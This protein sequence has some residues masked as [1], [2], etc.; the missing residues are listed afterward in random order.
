MDQKIETK[1]QKGKSKLQAK[2][3]ALQ[4]E[5]KNIHYRRL[6]TIEK[7][8]FKSAANPNAK[9]DD[10]IRIISDTGVLYQAMGT[11]SKKKGALT[12]G[13]KTDT[14]TADSSSQELIE[15]LSKS[16]KNG[17]FRF[18]PI[19][20]I[21]M[22]KSGKEPVTEEQKEK[23]LKL[24]QQGKVTMDQIKEIKARPL[25]IPSFPDKIVQE[26]MRMVLNAIYEP[27]FTRIQ[28]NFG[29]RPGKGCQD[30]IHQIQQKAKAMD[31]A[32]E[33][34]I[35]GAFDN[36]SH[37][38]LIKILEKKVEDRKFLKLIW[39]GLKCGVIFL[40]YRQDSDIGTT[41][42]SVLS[43]LLYN[44]Y[45]HEFDNFIC[46][47]FQEQVQNINNTENRKNDP[48]NKLYDN[49]K[50][51]RGK[52]KLPQL[53]KELQEAY[54]RLGTENEKVKELANKLK[55]TKK[56]HKILYKE[57]IKLKSKARSRQT[58]RYW[59]TRYAD[60]WIFLTNADINRV[61]EWKKY[62]TEWIS[63][64]L[65]LTVS[66]EKTKITNIRKGEKAKFLGFS[67]TMSRKGRTILMGNIKKTSTSITD[68]TK[69]K[70]TKIENKT[71][72]M[73]R[74]IN[75]TVIVTWDRQRVL[76]RLLANGFITRRQN[77]TIGKSKRAWSVLQEPEI[78]E[79][80][81]Y[82]IRGYLN[83]YSPVIDYPLDLSL[84]YYYLKYSCV[85]TL[86]QKR[87]TTLKKIFTK[88]G[89]DLKIKYT[90]NVEILNKK[91][92]EREKTKVEKT[93]QLLTWEDCKKI[94]KEALFRTRQK[95]KEN[96]QDS[97][98][99]MNTTLDEIC[100][101]KINWRTSYKLTKHCAICGSE[102]KVEY[103]HVRHIRKGK[104]A[105]FL[106]LMNQLNRKQIPV[107]QKC[108]NNIH[109]GEYD[110]MTLNQ[111]YDEELIIL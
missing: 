2:R 68:R 75:T 78:I 90:E 37:P 33:G 64:H 96:K 80:Y 47:T 52:L 83:Y 106:Q 42:G 6:K 17:T 27:E 104:V 48:V 36:V 25:G 86:A 15:E 38:I 110:G 13:A 87:K 101:V 93:A 55:E 3:E 88:H 76:D 62:F 5:Y 31:Y 84:L 12:P 65:K 111:V 107:C 105:G 41:Q 32:I 91:T 69:I 103:H 30:A 8:A 43:P 4:E 56:L 39:G 70:K 29:F 61:I 35:K 109:K 50:Y 72:F 34:D 28:R 73:K 14:R 63:E 44:I 94:M 21:Y 57:Q 85:H 49:Y 81:N 79:R 74:T 16:L 89:K 102:N 99:L 100:N 22:D 11:I 45:F 20:R 82:I 108:H 77:K 71:K 46:T 67:L 60:D 51:R 92:K 18:K 59:Y 19:R 1:K 40:N 66:E 9:F 54:E 58:I 98:S 24:H 26:A 95:Q 97:I 53:V 7:I 23:L 10:L